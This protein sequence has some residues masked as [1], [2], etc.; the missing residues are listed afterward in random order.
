[1]AITS[2][3]KNDRHS[4]RPVFYHWQTS[5]QLSPQERSYLDSLAVKKLYAKFFDVDWDEPSGLAVPFATIEIDT[6]RLYGLEIVPTIFITNRTFSHLDIDAVPTLA[7]RVLKK[8]N[9]LAQPLQIPVSA[10]QFDCDWTAST[11]EK[12]F[13]FLQHFKIKLSQSSPGPFPLT[14]ATIRLHQLKFFEK[15]GVPP[16]DKGMLMCYNMGDLED[17]QTENSIF[18]LK[19]AEQY[20]PEKKYPLPL[21]IALPLFRWGVVFREGE[22]VRLINGLDASALRDTAFFA[23]TAPSRFAVKNSNYLQGQYLYKG[24]QLRLEAVAVE[25]LK[26]TAHLFNNVSHPTSME[27]AFYHLDTAI[28]KR[29]PAKTISSVLEGF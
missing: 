4:I 16:V 5:L 10:Y 15:T 24:D 11:Q 25:D 28:V 9:S 18:D 2:C 23:Q 7:D 12:Y 8:I 19:I 20:L 3:K 21:D 14:S 1:M 13:A 29:F 22:L 17:W 26:K 27:V 6:A